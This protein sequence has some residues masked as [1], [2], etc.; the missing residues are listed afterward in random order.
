MNFREEFT[1][2]EPL[3]EMSNVLTKYTG[4][5]TTIWISAKRGNHG[6]RIK[7]YKEKNGSGSSFTVTVSDEPKVIGTSFLKSKELKKVVEFIKLNKELLLKFWELKIEDP[8]EV[9]TNFQKV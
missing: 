3:Y 5:P 2:Q 8:V 1:N 9:I 4:L 7:I 6:A